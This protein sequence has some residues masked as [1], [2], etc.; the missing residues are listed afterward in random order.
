MPARGP[1]EP[2]GSWGQD[3]ERV[4]KALDLPLAIGERLKFDAYFVEQ[5][6]MQTCQ[7]AW[8]I[9][10]QVSTAFHSASG[11]TGDKNRKIRMVM[12]VGVTHPTSVEIQCVIK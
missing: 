10:L 12:Y 7:R 1:S 8:F 3:R 2:N 4:E 11:T 5:R 9:E 6:Q